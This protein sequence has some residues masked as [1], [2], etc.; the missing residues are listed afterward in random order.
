MLSV[1]YHRDIAVAEEQ[2]WI[3]VFYVVYESRSLSI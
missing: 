1:F 3:A 2:A